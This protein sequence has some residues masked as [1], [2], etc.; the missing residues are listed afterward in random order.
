MR[1]NSV[2]FTD[3]SVGLDHLSGSCGSVSNSRDCKGCSRFFLKELDMKIDI[4]RRNALKIQNPM[5]LLNKVARLV[6]IYDDCNTEDYAELALSNLKDG[7]RK[8]VF[9]NFQFLCNEQIFRLRALNS[10]REFVPTYLGESRPTA[11]ELAYDIWYR[12]E[13]LH[14][15]A[16]FAHLMFQ[17]TL[18]KSV[19]DD[20][21]ENA[22]ELF[23]R[24]EMSKLGTLIEREF[25]DA[26]RQVC[27]SQCSETEQRILEELDGGIAMT[28]AE[29]EA[30]LELDI[31]DFA[32]SKSS[33]KA[34]LREL[35]KKELIKKVPNSKGKWSLTEFCP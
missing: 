12:M 5:G 22:K 23:D 4:E 17:R 15:D 27:F 28:P 3:T 26:N 7:L 1:L 35:S 13:K 29:L 8:V 21:F 18:D 11:I 31:R 30:E 16:D 25:F 33:I 6:W 20:F 10:K 19:V 24:E 2:R 32:K 9:E 34:A 14:S